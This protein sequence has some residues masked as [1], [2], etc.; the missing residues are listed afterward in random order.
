MALF[1]CPECQ[2][3]NIGTPKLLDVS[4]YTRC[5]DCRIGIIWESTMFSREINPVR[6]YVPE[7]ATR[8]P[9]TGDILEANRIVRGPRSVIWFMSLFMP[10]A[11]KRL[12]RRKRREGTLKGDRWV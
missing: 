9:K 5:D 11:E 6:T 4:G 8:S 12:E 3:E 7:G 10:L 2:S 1:E